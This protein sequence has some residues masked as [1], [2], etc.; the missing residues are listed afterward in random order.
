MDPPPGAPPAHPAARQRLPLPGPRQV[1]RILRR[2]PAP[3]PGWLHGRLPGPRGRRRTVR[4]RVPARL[5]DQAGLV[6]IATDDRMIP[7]PA[8]TAMSERIGAQTVAVAG[9]HSIYVSQPDAVADFIRQA[10]S[11]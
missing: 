3:R 11:S 5:A 4:H 9:S 2:R 7:P 1:P 10:A 6:V 8:Q